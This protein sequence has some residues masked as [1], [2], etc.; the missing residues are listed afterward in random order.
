MINVK[1]KE[2]V[3]VSRLIGSTNNDSISFK[4]YAEKYNILK[5]SQNFKHQCNI[6]NMV[7]QD[8]CLLPE[9][10]PCIII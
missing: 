6:K 8:I 9:T 3:K 7:N 2:H 4:S 5:G 1:T 10:F